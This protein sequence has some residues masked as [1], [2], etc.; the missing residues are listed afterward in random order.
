MEDAMKYPQ[1]FYVVQLFVLIGGVLFTQGALAD[2][3]SVC[4]YACDFTTIQAAVDVAQNGDT[5]NISNGTYLEDIVIKDKSL[6]C[7]SRYRA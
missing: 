5:I 2:K 6:S 3:Y 4:E 1:G 7:Q